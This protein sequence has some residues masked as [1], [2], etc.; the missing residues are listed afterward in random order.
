M[1]A[2]SRTWAL[3]R[4]PPRAPGFAWSRARPDNRVTREMALEHLTEMVAGTDVP[5]N[6]D[7]ENGFAANAA[8]VEESVRLAVATGVAG[9]SIEDSTGDASR[10]LFDLPDAVARIAAARRAIDAAGGDTL[11]VGR[12][13]CF[14]VGRP[15]L[16]RDDRAPAGL[17]AGR[18]R[19]PLR[20]RPAHARADR[21]G[22]AGA[23]AQARQRADRRAQRADGDRHRRARRAPHQ[24][25]RRA[26]A[27]GLGGF[28]RAA[29]ACARGASTALPTRRPGR[30]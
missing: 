1:L 15:D 6:A 22:G 26:G 23:G 9:L 30:S 17:C 7:F 2:G 27:R 8:G 14:L 10:P 21:G 16:G 18:R 28:Q 5:I 25:G 13:E 11:L 3:W 19:L 29:Q 24:R 4:W 20:A 12:A